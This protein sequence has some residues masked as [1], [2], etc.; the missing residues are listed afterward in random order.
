MAAS[1]V[2]TLHNYARE[3]ELQRVATWEFP[4]SMPDPSARW[5]IFIHG[6]AWR[7]PS[8]TYR[9][10]VPT[11]E[12][13]LSSQ[14]VPQSSIRGFASIDYRLSTHPSHP[15]DPATPADRLRCAKHPDH[16]RDVCLAL[17]YLQ[18]KYNVR[19]KYILIGHSVGATLAF[20]LLMGGQATGHG[21][22][23]LTG[24]DS[25]PLPAAIVGVAGIYEFYDFA[26]RHGG[27]Y[28]TMVEGAL[29]A[30]HSKWNAAAPLKASYVD[31]W[32]GDRRTLLSYSVEDSLV[33]G[34]PETTAMADRLRSDGIHTDIT[35]IQGEHDFAWQDGKQIAALVAQI[36]GNLEDSE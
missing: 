28:I 18:A 31:R 12:A 7:D 14:S 8:N 36:H 32:P 13:I 3:H 29:G 17:R 25:L 22:S 35:L 6:G 20:Q 19:D 5:I 30:D 16:I 9:D 34:D 2:F 33:D 27:P 4:A 11:I 21:S 10:F 26:H 24:T 1:L 15:Q 23:E